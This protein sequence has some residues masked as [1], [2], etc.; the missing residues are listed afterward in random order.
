MDLVGWIAAMP[1]RSGRSRPRDLLHRQCLA[2][3]VSP[4]GVWLRLCESNKRSSTG[5]T[6]GIMVGAADS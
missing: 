4:A 2:C 6:A 5:K 1:S 3:R